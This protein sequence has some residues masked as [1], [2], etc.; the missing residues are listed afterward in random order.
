MKSK[1][2]LFILLISLL[3]LPLSCNNPPAEVPVI[4]MDNPSGTIDLKI[5]DLLDN[6]TI[7]PLESNDHLILT[8]A[9]MSYIVTD[10]YILVSAG[11]KFLQFNRNGKYIKT[12]AI[13]GNGPNEYNYIINPMVDE[14]RNTLYFTDLKN[15][16]EV[17]SIDLVTGEFREFLI[18]NMLSNNIRAIDDD[19]NLYGFPSSST[20]RISSLE[21]GKSKE[22]SDSLMLVYKYHP[23]KQSMT[24][25]NGYHGFPSS[26]Q[27][28]TIFRQSN[29]ILFFFSAYSDTLYRI[30]EELLVPLYAIKLK[31]AQ[32]EIIQG[33]VF[34]NFLLS[35]SNSMV[36]SK[37]ESKFDIT[38]SAGNITRVSISVDLLAYLHLNNKEHLQS[39]RSM[40]IDLLS[41]TIDVDDYIKKEN[42]ENLGDIPIK[43][44]PSVSG[45]WAHYAVEA[46]NMIALIN[47][48]L[49]GHELTSSQ[50]KTL[51]EVA[52]Q[53]DEESNPV[54]IIGKI[55]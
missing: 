22:T 46:Y 32:T 18:P 17:I 50:R 34:L 43:P 4:D 36:I 49:K 25:F 15:Q 10:H 12:L 11:E 33:G 2:L 35:G 41:L 29:N 26:T 52:A 54:L 53:I 3:L 31:K 47:D 19:G 24:L 48:A 1:N 20:I 8:T 44:F 21:S 9:G 16:S 27:R 6:I 40:T 30:K 23:E 42:N 13:K 37:T 28:N 7:V 14:K 39:I 38:T 55:K 5:S 51:E 45:V